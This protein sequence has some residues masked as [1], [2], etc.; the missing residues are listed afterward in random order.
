MLSVREILSRFGGAHFA[1]AISI[2]LPA[3]GLFAPTLAGAPPF[4]RIHS[5]VDDAERF[6]L[7]G[8]TYP[9][10]ERGLLHEHGSVAPGRLMPH[11][12]MHFRMT[13]AQQSDLDQLLR[14]QQDRRSPV[15]HQF[16]TPE[17][18]A[19]RFGLSDSDIAKVIEWLQ[20]SGFSDLH[21]ARSKTWVSFSGTAAQ[22]EAAFHVSLRQYTIS[23]G[24]VHFANANNPELPKALE[25]VVDSVRGLHDFAMKPLH[26]RPRPR[27]STDSSTHYLAPDDWATIYDVKPLYTAGINGSG[28]T[29]A[30]AGQ[31]DISLTDIRAFRSAAGLSANDPSFVIPPGDRDP[32]IQSS[33]GD[34]VESDLDV[35]WAGA[36][37]PNA[38]IVFVTA[39]A[40][41][42]NGV[43]DAMTYAIDQNVAPILS[44]SYGL[45][46][47]DESASDFQSMESL[48]QQA[49]AQ[50]MTIVASSGDYGAAACDDDSA[51][52]THG[53]AVLYP[54]SSAY[55]TGLGGTKFNDNSSYWSSTN[56]AADGSALS[57]IPETAWDDDQM[58]VA[59]AT[60]GGA[61]KLVQKPS[62]QTGQGV[63]SD[64]ARDVPDLA[65]TASLYTDPLLICSDG[66]C[67]NGFLDATGNANTIGGTSAATPPF[68]GVLALV[69]QRHAANGRLGNINPNLYSLAQIQSNVLHDITDGD[70]YWF[71]QT[72]TTDCASGILGFPAGAG[73]DQT[74]GWGS[75]DAYNFAEQWYGDF[76]MTINPSSLT[77]Q[78][79]TS[80]TATVDITPQ[81]NFSG[82]VTITCSVPGTLL[83]VTCSVPNTPI[84]S[85]GTTTVTISAAATAHTPFWKRLHIQPPRSKT[86]LPIA[87]S[88]LIIWLTSTWLLWKR[89]RSTIYGYTVTSAIFAI[90]MGTVACGGGSGGGTT[91]TTSPQPQALSM[92]CNLP[93]GTLRSPYS[94]SCTT[95]GGTSP[96]TFSLSSGFLPSGLN[97]NSSTGAVAGTPSA[98]GTAS[99]VVAAQDSSSPA[100]VATVSEPSFTISAKPAVLSCNLPANATVSSPY[101]GQC[102][103]GG[104]V[105]PYYFYVVNG[106]LP[107]GLALNQSTGAITGT[108]TTLGTS[109]FTVSA[110]DSQAPYDTETLNITNLNVAAGILVLYCPG[111]WDGSIAKPFSTSCPA[112]GGTPPYTYSWVSGTLPAGLSYDAS[113]DT[114]S[115]LPSAITAPG[116]LFTVSVSDS[117]SPVQHATK[118]VALE[119]DP[120]DPFSVSCPATLTTAYFGTLSQAECNV[121]GGNRPMTVTVSSGQLP[122]GFTLDSQS[123]L[124]AGT[125]TA[126]GTY[127]FSLHFVDGSVPAQTADATTSITVGP[128]L[129]QSA[130]VTITATS[131]G[132]VITKTIQVAVP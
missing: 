101:S 105:G 111:G 83:D 39:S 62:W 35:E 124:I 53:L 65:F 4:T 123:G 91:V 1:F 63:P 64:G 56:N 92:T 130:P 9:A 20:N 41:S 48:F 7:P 102:S 67:T 45:C 55:V 6:V 128:R 52:A 49:N 16:L 24:V 34:E 90:A 94:G 13:E 51:P 93:P 89:K 68:A 132:I 38:H 17:Q 118:T 61:S 79:G 73:Y 58:P 107:P 82:P 15:Y 71:C 32:G 57:Y 28:V 12:V 40:T 74:T 26:T 98:V 10:I 30:V 75:I 104:G 66:S 50:G 121:T 29:I 54:A 112:I 31:S 70:N 114:V 106:T 109:S 84:N 60:G 119:I 77:L 3:T 131:G 27:Y 103:V 8:T 95:S 120:V 127:T 23:A 5:Y 129:P 2:L 43:F 22:T 14:A 113:T 76:Q 21:I 125:P 33:T 96:I 85:S 97:L 36:I 59:G 47:A 78:P 99:F 72:G 81:N 108:P 122:P 126:M 44:I 18:Y 115:G 86:M 87:C 37:A 110:D 11:M 25:G 116:D 42:G 88:S 80:A 46:E 69:I 19:A 100:Q 117:S